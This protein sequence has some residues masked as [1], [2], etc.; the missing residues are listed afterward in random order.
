M[1][2]LLLSNSRSVDGSYLVHAIPLIRAISAGCTRVLFVPFAGVTVS[3]DEYTA[4]VQAVMEPLGLRLTGAHTV[5]NRE[6]EAAE[7]I[8][9][10]GGNTFRLLK[11]CRER[12]LLDAIR[13][14]V[15]AGMPYVGWSAGAIMAS[16][17]IRTTNDMPIV[18]P[19]GFDALGLVDF[20]INAHYTNELPAGHQGETRN[21][22]L[23]EYL[24]VNP[25][26]L[27]VALPEGA[28]LNVADGQAT[29]DGIK[30]GYVFRQGADAQE[31]RAGQS[32]PAV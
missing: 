4:N 29:F 9:V 12:G 16:P 8:M 26:D 10:G 17:T 1:K 2:L 22:R 25:Q 11:E 18:D 6:V 7:L 23:A 13:T 32:V 31:L 28:W 5:S 30:A 14:R 19:Q 20:Q 15:R 24:V 27:V 3:W 21:Q